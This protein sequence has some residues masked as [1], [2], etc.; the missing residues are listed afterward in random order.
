M[1][2]ENTLL[3]ESYYKSDNPKASETLKE[4]YHYKFIDLCR[5][6][7][8][9]QA[10]EKVNLYQRLSKRYSNHPTWFLHTCTL[11]TSYANY[12]ENKPV[13]DEPKIGLLE[14]ECS[15]YYAL[16]KNAPEKQK[17]LTIRHIAEL[18]KGQA[19]VKETAHLRTLP[20]QRARSEFLKRA[21]CHAAFSGTFAEEADWK[22]IQHTGIICVDLEGL[23]ENLDEYRSIINADPPTIMSFSNPLDNGL[24]VLYEMT[25]QPDIQENCYKLFSGYLRT[26]CGLPQDTIDSR[27]FK[28]SRSTYLS[29]DP[30]IFINPKFTN[31]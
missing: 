28:V 30:R 14:N 31:L 21:F 24:R 7:G 16:N 5:E 23:G 11:L 29:H 12:C 6:E 2:L 27:Y 25:T 4:Y 13:Q 8:E 9:A 15:V 20:G 17:S 3:Q 1:S 18:I 19:F 26:I 10:L 22:L